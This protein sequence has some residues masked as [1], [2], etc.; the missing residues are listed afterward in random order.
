MGN[1][2][3]FKLGSPTVIDAYFDEVDYQIS[4]IKRSV[5]KKSMFVTKALTMQAG[6]ISDVYLNGVQNTRLNLVNTAVSSYGI[7]QTVD[8]RNCSLA[9]LRNMIVFAINNAE[10]EKLNA[11]TVLIFNDAINGTGGTTAEACW[12]TIDSTIGNYLNNTGINLILNLYII[13]FMGND[14]ALQENAVTT[15]DAF[16]QFLSIKPDYVKFG[17]FE[18]F[19]SFNVGGS[20]YVNNLL[21]AA[22]NSFD[23]LCKNRSIVTV[24]G[25]DASD[26]EEAALFARDLC[27]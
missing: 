17:I 6:S 10:S 20:D 5:D 24:S 14:A 3:K 22:T 1:K 16:N 27:P 11:L 21:F 26:E 12:E 7:P 23:C 15:A 18:T 4:C 19:D 25:S 2:L 8:I 9:T 13:R